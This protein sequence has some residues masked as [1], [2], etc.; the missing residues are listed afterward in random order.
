MSTIP[1]THLR[2]LMDDVVALQDHAHKLMTDLSAE[3]GFARKR[4]CD[5]TI[6]D[7]IGWGLNPWALVINAE[8]SATPE[9]HG[10]ILLTFEDEHSWPFDPADIVDV[11]AALDGPGF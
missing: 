5:V 8:Q 9:G 11:K 10:V 4:I 1:D 7:E 3:A 6:G 2:S